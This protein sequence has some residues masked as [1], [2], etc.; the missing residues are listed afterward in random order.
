[1]NYSNILER[2]IMKTVLSEFGRIPFEWNLVELSYVSEVIDPHPSHRAPK[3]VEN[4]FPFVGIG[5]IDEFGNI[6]GA[7]IVSEE[8]IDEHI[9]NYKINSD[10]IGYGRVGTVGKVVKFKNRDK[11]KY[12]LAPTLAVI[13]PKD[14]I[15]ANFLY[16]VIRSNIF[17]N[18]VLKYATGSTRPSI[19][20]QLLRKIKIIYPSI[21]EQIKI[22][23]IINCLDEKIEINRKI[24]ENLEEQ[25]KTIFK[26]WFV[27]YEFPNEEGKP[28]KSS[29]G[30]ML[31]S[32]MG[33]I[34]KEWC[35]TTLGNIV[36]FKNGYAFK[37]KDLFDK[38]S[39]ECYCV[40]KQGHIK[41][42]GGF[43]PS[44]TKSW[45]LKSSAT[46]LDKFILYK[47]DILMAM[48]DMKGNVAILGNTAI[49]PVDNT[50]IL[51]QRVALL[52]VNELNSVS[53]VFVYLLTNSIHF[54]NDLRSRANSGVQV[55][56]SMNEIKL[57]K[58]ALP[59][60]NVNIKFNNIVL[61]IFDKIISN[62]HEI[63]KL[64]QIRDTLLPKL[65]TG[66]IDVSNI[67]I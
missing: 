42:G 22:G 45:Y 51:N 4:G 37:S 3:A 50:Y 16:A 27:D 28:Y 29:G 52:R 9:K 61:P 55:N 53:Y 65:M 10:S 23:K 5:D 1:M 34:P 47:G 35:V 41:K 15:D 18:Q 12:A 33:L 60:S 38:P 8:I 44:A 59:I 49:M 24:N 58:L 64:T 54:I 11:F 62:Q 56:L 14:N 20:I 26:R 21:E 40:F 63:Q 25:A 39:P 6:K 13:N 43:N 31:E 48:T 7:R 2:N 17:L 67:D 66:E 57:S 46:K 19:G 36:N 32:E 30:E